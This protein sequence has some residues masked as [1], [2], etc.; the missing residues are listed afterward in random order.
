MRAFPQASSEEEVEIDEEYE[1][2]QALIPANLADANFGKQTA[3]Q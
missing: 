1:I 2:H 3:L